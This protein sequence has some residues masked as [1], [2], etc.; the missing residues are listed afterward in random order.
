M[1][2]TIKKLISSDKKI[3]IYPY[4]GNGKLCE[5]IL[6]DK[7]EVKDYILADNVVKEDGKNIF[8]AAQLKDLADVISVIDT[9]RNPL[10]HEEVL[11]E[12]RKYVDQENI[13]SVFGLREM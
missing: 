8:R 5:K 13:H 7:Y 10:I 12:I 1:E 3:V 11:N 4:G 6:R 9:C 2:Q